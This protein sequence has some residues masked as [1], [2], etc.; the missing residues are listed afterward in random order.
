M[1]QYKES[2][3]LLR[4]Q[5]HNKESF[6]HFV[7]TLKFL[8]SAKNLDFS[9][10]SMPIEIKKFTVLK[11]PHV[12]KKA[13]ERYEIRLYNGLIL[14]KGAFLKNKLIHS[15]NANISSDLLVKISFRYNQCSN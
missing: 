2:E 1:K 4:F 14:L 11:S 8:A 15:I 3:L 7:K 10:I 13:K 6:K 12:N 9:F 5:T